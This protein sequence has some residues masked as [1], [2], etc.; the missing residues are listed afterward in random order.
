MFTKTISALFI[1]AII[2]FAGAYL[3]NIDMGGTIANATSQWTCSY[4]YILPQYTVT[5]A[6]VKAFLKGMKK[7]DYAVMGLAIDKYMDYIIWFENNIGCGAVLLSPRTNLINVV[8]HDQGIKIY[9]NGLR[10]GDYN[11]S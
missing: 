5:D 4:E 8:S 10:K 3:L 1:A 11:H 6:K 9:K 2:F 7:Q